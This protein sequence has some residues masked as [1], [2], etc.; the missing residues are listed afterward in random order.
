MMYFYLLCLIGEETEVRVVKSLS[1]RHRAEILMRGAEQGPFD[2]STTG[3]EDLSF[4]QEVHLTQ[5]KSPVG[6]G[7]LVTPYGLTTQVMP[8]G[9]RVKQRRLL[10]SRTFCICIQHFRGL[11]LTLPMVDCP[12]GRGFFLPRKGVY[13]L[14]A[15]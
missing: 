3:L 15:A 4:C 6:A 13:I 12:L 11:Y 2:A 7:V 8:A 5:T 14:M 1:Q 10:P 9:H